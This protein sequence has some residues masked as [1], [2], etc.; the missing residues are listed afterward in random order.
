[1][2]CNSISTLTFVLSLPQDEDVYISTD[3]GASPPRQ[4]AAPHVCSI[5]GTPALVCVDC[6]LELLCENLEGSRIGL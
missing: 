1:M 3:I 2:L 4:N 6:E 5:G